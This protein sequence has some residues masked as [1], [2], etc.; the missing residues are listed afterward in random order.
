MLSHKRC[1]NFI[2]GKEVVFWQMPSLVCNFNREF[3]AICDL[4]FLIIYQ[5]TSDHHYYCIIQGGGKQKMLFIMCESKSLQLHIWVRFP[6][7]GILLKMW[8]FFLKS[9]AFVWPNLIRYIWFFNWFWSIVSC[10][11]WRNFWKFLEIF[12][13]SHAASLF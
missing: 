5:R 4:Y 1:H 8:H 10:S 2:Q 7:T 12:L 13:E 11:L 3:G 9:R 6:R